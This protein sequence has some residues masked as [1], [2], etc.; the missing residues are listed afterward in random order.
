MDM[1]MAG[2]SDDD[3]GERFGG[4]A[5][6]MG[7]DG[8]ARLQ[9]A[10]VAVIGVGG[11][12]SWAA[13]ALIRSGVGGLLLVDLDDVCVT[14]VNRQLP[15]LDGTIGRPK[16]EV[17]AERL[18]AIHPTAA[19]QPLPEFFTA[20]TAEAILAPPL[21]HVVDAID[22]PSLKALLAAECR[23]RGVP[24]ILS[25]G[26]GGRRDPTRIRVAD[27]A[28]STHDGLLAQVRRLLRRRH[29]FP[30]AGRRMGVECAFT[31]EPPVFPAPDGGVC[32]NREAAG[33][34]RLDC[35]SGYGTACFVTGAFGFA[36]ASRVVQ[37]LAAGG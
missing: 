13:E 36:L 10:R 37:R 21:D 23:R 27:L 24:V 9:A 4:V 3:A 6:L 14:N 31:P 19:I 29:G 25:G 12:G 8:L 35:R 5:R 30:A 1:T 34:L 17:M 28:E 32:A 33:D 18:R 2:T 11:V 16:V 26:A 7:R 22:S 15:A 20:E